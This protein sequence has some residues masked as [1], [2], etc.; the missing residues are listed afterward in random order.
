VLRGEKTAIAGAARRRRR[1][2]EA[3]SASD[4]AIVDDDGAAWR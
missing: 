2:G 4:L 1:D 3:R